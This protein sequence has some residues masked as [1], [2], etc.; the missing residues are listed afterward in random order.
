MKLDTKFTVPFLTIISFVSLIPPLTYYTAFFMTVVLLPLY[1]KDVFNL[2]TKNKLRLN[3]F[4]NFTFIFFIAFALIRSLPSEN[5]YLAIREVILLIN[6]A[7]VFSLSAY[8]GLHKNTINLLIILLSIISSMLIFYVSMTINPFEY[9]A[10]KSEQIESKNPIALRIVFITAI[11]IAL[12]GTEKS[13]K[14]RLRLVLVSV[15]LI[16]IIAMFFLESSRALIYFFILF[17]IPII[18]KFGKKYPLIFLLVS[19]LSLGYIFLE[20]DY[21][22]KS[23]SS[24]SALSILFYKLEPYIEGINKYGLI[25]G[26][27]FR[28]EFVTIAKS[29]ALEGIYENPFFGLGPDNSRV[30]YFQKYGEYTNSHHNF[31]ELLLNY[32]VF[33]AVLWYLFLGLYISNIFLKR[34]SNYFPVAFS[35]CIV[36]LIASTLAPI[37]REPDIYC[38]MGIFL[39]LVNKTDMTCAK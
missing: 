13:I 38:M 37:Y 28:A 1:L 32:G 4:V 25:Q 12:L 33:G 24:F 17:F 34:G 7:V 15:I 3:E 20:Y 23:A 9:V 29:I 14:L 21:I 16:N 19:V 35:F 31:Y 10:F 11:F 26:K 6:C 39:V 30:L 8:W 18:M 5:H 27:P 2:L 22:L 36:L